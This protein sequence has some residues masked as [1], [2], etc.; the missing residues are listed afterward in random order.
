[1]PLTLTE[2][3]AVAEM[4]AFLYSFLP[5]K[6]HPYADQAMSFP[7]VAARSGLGAFWPGGSKQPALLH[8]L[9]RT[10]DQRRDQ[11]CG[12]I[13]GIV[14]EAI[15]YRGKKGD[16][17]SRED[18]EKLNRLIVRVGFKIPEL[19]DHQ[20]LASLPSVAAEPGE[21]P[22]AGSQAPAEP[23]TA[24]LEEL[25]A[26]FLGLNSLSPQERGFYFERFLRDVFKAFGLTP[27]QAFRLQGEQIDGSFEFEGATYLVEAKWQTKP[28]D[29][30][31]LLIF[32]GK[33]EGKAA[34][35]RGLI[36]SVGGFSKDGLVA[37]RQGRRASI[38]GMDGQDLYLILAGE[39]D[40]KTVLSLKARR[41]AET[42]EIMVGVPD[43]LIG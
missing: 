7:G 20:F 2:T 26:A 22:P 24:R 5:G 19:W 3:Q 23:S 8:L 28:V 15:K 27:R 10:L 9:E 29:Q 30:A 6:P 32:H 34:W 25:R 4:A 36:I 13:V 11:F 14:Q 1:M 37:F 33:V 16:P 43:L 38:I 12:L 17:V 18:I 39:L 35:S 40:L 31:A 42:G 21:E 41:A